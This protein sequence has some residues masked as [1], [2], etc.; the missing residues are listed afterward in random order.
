MLYMRQIYNAVSVW[1]SHNIDV[2]LNKLSF[3]LITNISFE[4]THSFES[5]QERKVALI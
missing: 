5:A 4:V 3:P 2:F 1:G